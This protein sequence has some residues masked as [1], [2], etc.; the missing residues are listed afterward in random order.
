MGSVGA[1]GS[2]FQV[3]GCPKGRA[4]WV[5]TVEGEEKKFLTGFDSQQKAES[6]AKW[7]ATGL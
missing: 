3:E 7:M 1:N 5:Y 2:A 4:F 6:F